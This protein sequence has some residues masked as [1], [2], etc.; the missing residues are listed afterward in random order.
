RAVPQAV[1]RA[2]DVF[3]RNDYSERFR[4]EYV[5]K[6]L[7]KLYI[8]SFGFHSAVTEVKRFSLVKYFIGKPTEPQRQSP[9]TWAT[10]ELTLSFSDKAD[11]VIEAIDVNVP[12][13]K[14]YQRSELTAFGLS[15][16]VLDELLTNIY[17]DISTPR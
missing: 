11:I 2:N 3:A 7:A 13:H 9:T 8:D 10:Y 5:G 16:E 12:E 4:F 15:D 14:R 6:R 1:S 17:A